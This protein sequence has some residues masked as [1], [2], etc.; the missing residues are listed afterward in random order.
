MKVHRHARFAISA[1]APAFTGLVVLTLA[2]GIGA[3]TAMF[4]VVDAVLINPLPFAKADRIVEVWTYFQEGA[5]RAPGCD[6]HRRLDDSQGA[7]AVRGDQRLSNWLPARSPARGEPELVCRCGSRPE[8]LLRVSNGA[9]RRPALQC[10][11]RDILGAS[12]PDQRADVDRALRP[13]SWVIDRIVTIDD[14][15]NRIVGVLP[16]RFN[17][18]ESTVSVWRPIDIES[19]NARLRVPARRHSCEPGVTRTAV[20]DRL[21]AITASLLESGALPKGQYLVADEPVQVGYGRS[22]ARSLYMLLGAV[23]VLLLVACVNITNLILVRSSSRRGELALMAAL[24]AG[25][26]RL[27]RDAAIESAMLAVIGGA[28]GVW[29]A[30]GLLRVIL[31]LAPERPVD[32]VQRDR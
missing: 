15:P 25:R 22:G 10:G 28:L 16:T 24:G 4:S 30:G 13:R 19:A 5:V 32:A 1:R 14:V 11:R 20:D 3:T 6:E 26:T 31:G 21:K 17:V 29:L 2:L 27:L 23:G 9:A 12:D 18:P 7:W 8:H